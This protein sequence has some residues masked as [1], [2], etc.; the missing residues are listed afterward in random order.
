M[1]T[2]Y[3]PYREVLS[4]QPG[5]SGGQLSDA[6]NY[7]SFFLEDLHF[8]LEMGSNYLLFV[9]EPQLRLGLPL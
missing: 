3:D 7:P 4:S 5:L 6:F 8:P 9:S 1:G 2:R